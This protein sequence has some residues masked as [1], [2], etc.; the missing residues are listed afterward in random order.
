MEIVTVADR[1]ERAGEPAGAAVPQT[2]N[3]RKSLLSWLWPRAA[4]MDD[5]AFVIRWKRVWASGANARWAG[6]PESRN[7]HEAGSAFA[8]AWKAG[9][10]WGDR[11]PDRREP[12]VVRFAVPLRRATDSVSPLRRSARAGAVGLSVI[13]VAGWL[14]QTRRRSRGSTP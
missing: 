12:S 8:S 14:W 2:S 4:A 11:Q 6:V 5:D 9:W 1:P 10:L 13:A 3:V 7:P